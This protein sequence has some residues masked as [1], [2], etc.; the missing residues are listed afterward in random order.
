M[1][2]PAYSPTSSNKTICPKITVQDQRFE[3]SNTSQ[4]RMNQANLPLTFSA[5][6]SVSNTKVVSSSAQVKSIAARSV[7]NSA[8]APITDAPTDS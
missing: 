6:V 8:S 4:G 5:H 1:M 2:P 3:L 7:R